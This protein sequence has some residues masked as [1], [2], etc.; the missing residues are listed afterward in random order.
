MAIRYDEQYVKRPNTEI[1][2][3]QEQIQELYN[4][5]N[6]IDYFL[7]YVKI[8]NPDKGEMFFDPYDYQRDLLDKFAKNRYNV[9]LASRQSG[10]TTSVAAYVLWYS[11][12]HISSFQQL[13]LS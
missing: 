7:K 5:S 4:C 13:V 3:T 8:V 6:D 10:K 12:F 2:Y 1:E 9:V 11:L